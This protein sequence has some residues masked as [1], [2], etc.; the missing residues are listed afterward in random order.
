M[1]IQQLILDLMHKIGSQSASVMG[2]LNQ[3]LQIIND[4]CAT[5]LLLVTAIVQ[6]Q[7]QMILGCVVVMNVMFVMWCQQGF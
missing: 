4:A 1:T 3:R 2:L 7:L 6:S 5:N